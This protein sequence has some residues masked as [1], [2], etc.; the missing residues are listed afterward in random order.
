M[1]FIVSFT[2]SVALV[3][4][5]NA[6]FAEFPSQGP[7]P[8]GKSPFDQTQGAQSPAYPAVQQGPAS[9][10]PQSAPQ[11]AP[12]QQS[13]PP[14][15]AYPYGR[16]PTRLDVMP[17][18][19]PVVVARSG[20]PPVPRGWEE[21]VG[22]TVVV[23]GIAWGYDK[24]RGAYVI[25]NG[26]TINIFGDVRD[27]PRGRLVR[28]VGTFKKLPPFPPTPY[29]HQARRGY[30]EDRY[31]IENPQIE[32]VDRVTSLYLREYSFNNN[33][34]DALRGTAP[35]G[36]ANGFRPPPARDGILRDARGR[37]TGVWGVDGRKSLLEPARR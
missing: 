12:A 33:H 35:G 34:R 11:A 5:A 21:L 13:Y 16:N 26:Q 10:V 18:A 1:K 7:S 8:Y 24:G 30:P 20:P 27:F 36:T 25:C 32:V 17:A 9:S 15:G 14:K 3:A 2:L 19:N 22:K 29:G 31:G 28:V 37:P 23:E 6:S 4:M